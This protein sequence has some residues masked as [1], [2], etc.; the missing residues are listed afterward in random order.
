MRDNLGAMTE[1]TGLELL[2]TVVLGA[3]DDGGAREACLPLLQRVGGRIVES[4]DCS[5]EEPGCWS[6]TI[7]R[8]ADSAHPGPAALSRAVRSFLREL[9]SRY[10]GQRVAC[11]PPAAWAVIDDP[12]LVGELVPGGER[13]L[14]EAWAGGSVLPDGAGADD[15]AVDPGADDPDEPAPPA[16]EP[17]IDDVDE[18]G[19]PRARLQLLVDVVT[20]RRAGAEWP[21]RA[22]AAR[23]SGQPTIT[24]CSEHPP[25]VRVALD[26]GPSPGEPAEIVL[27]AVTAL[28]GDG[29][30]RLRVRD[31]SAMSRWSAA[32]T[33]PSGIAAVELNASAPDPAQRQ[34]AG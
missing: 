7:S 10:S 12:E 23:L 13:L 14:L 16:P 20:E 28:G 6:I 22:L 17:G 27:G 31:S 1:N 3:D 18:H 8:P 30:S 24:D 4:G 26:L 32:P 34:P 2:I 25:V 19:R 33:P 29:W 11:E 5:D 9:G 21:A 15:T